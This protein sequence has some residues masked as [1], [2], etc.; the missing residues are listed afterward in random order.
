[1]FDLNQ[2]RWTISRFKH[3]TFVLVCGGVAKISPRPFKRS[4]KV[5]ATFK[6]DNVI[7]NIGYAT[8]MGKNTL[9]KKKQMHAS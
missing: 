6:H 2:G 7:K 5:I 8:K 9:N 4:S 1:L 3:E